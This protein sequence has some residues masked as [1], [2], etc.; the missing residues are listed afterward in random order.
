MTD[1]SMPRS[2]T[3]A[4]VSLTAPDARTQKRK[5][6]EARFRMYGIAGIATG[7]FF[8]VVLLIAI[9]S[10]GTGAFQQTFINVPVYLDP[11]KLDFVS[12]ATSTHAHTDHLDHG[13]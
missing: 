5:A 12:F 6:A 10:S 8:L 7:L 13:T 4:R 9:V 2:E 3:V 1:A 11:A